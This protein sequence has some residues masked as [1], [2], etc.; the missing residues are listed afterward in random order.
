MRA[1]LGSYVIKP[2]ARRAEFWALALIRLPNL[3]FFSNAS[4]GLHSAC[5]WSFRNILFSIG[6]VVV[7]VVYLYNV[8]FL[9]RIVYIIDSQ[10]ITSYT[11]NLYLFC[12]ILFTVGRFPFW[13]HVLRFVAIGSSSDHS[14]PPSIARYCFGSNFKNTLRRNTYYTIWAKYYELK[15]FT[16]NS[17][18]NIDENKFAVDRILDRK[19]WSWWIKKFVFFV[20]HTMID[21]FVYSV[22]I[23]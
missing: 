19:L 3:I 10:Q 7:V 20:H 2:T 11:I 1:A 16:D 14:D 22:K 18:T 15:L 21:I 12:L 5:Y 8:D 17:S 4:A 13:T 9:K 6:Y 23:L